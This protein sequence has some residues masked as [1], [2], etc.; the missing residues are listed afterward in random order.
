[1]AVEGK[2]DHS[3][4]LDTPM[5]V[6]DGG[7][8]ISN[9]HSELKSLKLRVKELEMENASLLAQISN[10]H[11]QKLEKSLSQ[12]VV[13]SY[14]SENE[15]RKSGD[16]ELLSS[17]NSDIQGGIKPIHKIRTRRQERVKKGYMKS[18]HNYPQRYVAL[19]MM[20]FGKRLN[21]F[22]CEGENPTVESEL[23]E[24]LV[25]TRL[26][27]V[28]KSESQYSRCG[29][30]DKGVSSV[31]Q[32]IA[33]LLRSKLK[34]TG[35][36]E[37]CKPTQAM[38]DKEIDYV[39]VLNRALPNDIRVIGWC[40]VPSDFHARFSCL[41][42]E[43]KYLFW[44]TNLDTLSMQKAGM[45]FVGE[46][47]FRNFCKMDAVNVHHYMRNII[48]FDISSCDERSGDSQL[49]AMTIKGSAFLWHQVRCMA[50]V[51][52]MIGEGLES[53]SVIDELLD[54]NK[55]PRK[56]QYVMATELPLVLQSCEFKDLNFICSPDSEQGL[57]EHLTNEFKTYKLQAAIFLEALL[58]CSST[59]DRGPSVNGKKKATHIPLISR[60]TE[61]SYDER[62]AKHKSRTKS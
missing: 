20:Y 8:A 28:D 3:P 35:E 43:Y 6:L 21:G 17:K 39:R 57:M 54:T 13:S 14:N 60:P 56:P 38:Y 61:P 62:L 7:D 5:E 59:N 18:L 37:N 49:W 26:L 12:I 24:A 1:M 10:C 19:K 36:N 16:V 40:P 9:L 25:T 58:N 51:L 30:T 41:S 50:A 44:S 48:S 46:H 45:K 11:C 15:E 55:I 33:L 47:D 31:G 52:F 23:F 29:R 22:S 42:R 53:P 27:V 2:D 4:P 32:V 34:H